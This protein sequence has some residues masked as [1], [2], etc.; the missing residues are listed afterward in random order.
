MDREALGNNIAV[1]GTCSHDHI[2]HIDEFPSEDHKYMCELGESHCGGVATNVAV[3]LALLGMPVKLISWVGP[4]PSGRTIRDYLER[5]GVLTDGLVTVA[6]NTPQ[7]FILACRKTGTR[8]AFM[9]KHRRPVSLTNLQ[10]EQVDN[11]PITYYDGSRLE[12]SESILKL[13]KSVGASLFAN[14]ELA[15]AQAFRAL[16]SSH[17]AVASEQALC[18]G[19]AMTWKQLKSKLVGIWQPNHRLIGVTLGK[20]GS[21]F[22]DGHD[23]FRTPAI[24]VT[25]VDTTGA[26]DAFQA[27]LILGML[28]GWDL[29]ASIRFA[30]SPR[31]AKVYLCWAQLVQRRQSKY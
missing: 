30:S 11:C 16:L 26:G 6:E 9:T 4:D 2:L 15:S 3:N 25:E 22:F 8:T 23:F 29:L 1:I 12:V 20:R 13:C 21:L 28:R 19:K 18:Q 5:Q 7:V 24:N 17:F 31:S 27:G 14:Y 10:R